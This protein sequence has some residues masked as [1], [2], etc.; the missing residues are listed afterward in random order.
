MAYVTLSRAGS[1]YRGTREKAL[2]EIA[3][4]VNTKVSPYKRLRGGVEV[5]EEIPKTA[6][7][8]I[9]RR[10][11]PARLAMSRAAKL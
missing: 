3:A 4:F 11:L 5:L 10:L 9:L 8:K 7:G 2:N 1:E 6:S